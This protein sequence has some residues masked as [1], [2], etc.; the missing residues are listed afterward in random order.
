M[1]LGHPPH[2]GA[3]LE[4]YQTATKVVVGGDFASSKIFLV[5]LAYIYYRLIVLG[6]LIAGSVA[7][8]VVGPVGLA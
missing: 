5:V 3:L 1:V 2:V 8:V 6:F 4:R 7:V